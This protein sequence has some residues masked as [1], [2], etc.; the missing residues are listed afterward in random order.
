MK[1]TQL[2]SKWWCLAKNW[3]HILNELVRLK[4]CALSSKR[5]KPVVTPSIQCFKVFWRSI[6][7][8]PICMRNALT[9][10]IDFGDIQALC[11][12]L[13]PFKEASEILEGSLYVTFHGVLLICKKLER[14]EVHA[15][16][17]FFCVWRFHSKFGWHQWGG[18][19]SKDLFFWRCVVRFQRTCCWNKSV[20]VLEQKQCW[21]PRAIKIS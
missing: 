19:A 20:Q 4:E 7:F 14:L 15:S 21:I 6:K 10:N 18:K 17:K 2:W 3:L 13:E 12:F 5:L 9:I 1:A 11:T 16:D 8:V